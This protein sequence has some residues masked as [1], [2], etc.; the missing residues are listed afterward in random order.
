[1]TKSTNGWRARR[2]KDI[3]FWISFASQPP[4]PFLLEFYRFCKP[5]K[6]LEFRL[7]GFARLFG[8]DFRDD[9]N[10]KCHGMVWVLLEKLWSYDLVLIWLFGNDFWMKIRRF[11]FHGINI[12]LRNLKNAWFL[13]ENNGEVLFKK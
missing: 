7:D 8:N 5:S 3:D 11:L 4:L 9:Q 13:T 10:Q 6:C 12:M 2:I 1:M